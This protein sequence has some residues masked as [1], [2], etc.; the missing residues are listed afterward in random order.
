MEPAARAVVSI[1]L[2]PTDSATRVV[3]TTRVGATDERARRQF[4]AYW[5]VVRIGSAATRKALLS[6]V[7]RRALA[8]LAHEV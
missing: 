6:A 4:A 1:Q 7:E 5:R 2:T 3:T 8:L